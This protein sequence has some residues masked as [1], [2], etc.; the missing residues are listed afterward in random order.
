MSV[1]N[2]LEQITVNM[3]SS[4]RIGG[5]AV[6]YIDPIGIPD[7]PHDADILLITHPHFDHFSPRDIKKV[8]KDGTVIVC[9]KTASGL[10]RLLTGKEPVAV[11]PGQGFSLCGVS[12]ETVAAYNKIKPMH[13]R[14]FNFV[15]YVLTV[16]GT[17]VYI[18]GDTDDT[19]EAAAVKCDIAVIPIGGTY[20][21]N[22]VQAA[23]L[24]NK[25]AP[26]AVIPVHY[27]VMLGGHDAPEKF[28]AKLDPGIT[29]D[30]RPTVYSKV[31]L[32]VMPLF[33]AAAVLLVVCLMQM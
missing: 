22:P 12:I 20:T 32:R 28:R 31:M 2:T 7:A 23:E 29:A 5:D 10:C 6:I 24:V 25:I 18:S 26:Q 16:G 4:I 1:Q 30:I 15:G 19:P 3:H 11:I 17:R 21:V 9:P 8:M 27:G 14:P 33:A 13:A